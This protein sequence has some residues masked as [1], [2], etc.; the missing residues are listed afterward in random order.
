MVVVFMGIN[1][2]EMNKMSIRKSVHKK[3][4]KI[5]KREAKQVKKVKQDIQEV[6]VSIF[7]ALRL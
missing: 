5:N 3:H 2:D 1:L 6:E 7:I 4:D